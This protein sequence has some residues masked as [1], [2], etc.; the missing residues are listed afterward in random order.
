MHTYG[1]TEL[2]GRAGGLALMNM[3]ETG[4]CYWSSLDGMQLFAGEYPDHGLSVV[5]GK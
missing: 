3:L 4:R 1:S 2:R 5:G